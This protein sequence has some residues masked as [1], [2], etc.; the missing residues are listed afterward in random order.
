MELFVVPK[1]MPIA[2][3]LVLGAREDIR[4]LSKL[5]SARLN[6]GV[7]QSYHPQFPEQA[8]L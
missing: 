3:V 8:K 2:P 6:L 7:K 5:G 4:D 1:S